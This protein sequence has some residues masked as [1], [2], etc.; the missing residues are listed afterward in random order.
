MAF[1]LHG[2][3]ETGLA[4]RQYDLFIYFCHFYF[5]IANPSGSY[6]L[7]SLFDVEIEPVKVV[8]TATCD[9]KEARR[10][11]FQPKQKN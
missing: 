8:V 2:V 6:H 11:T 7:F 3:E 9:F 4:E 1:T 10:R 5:R